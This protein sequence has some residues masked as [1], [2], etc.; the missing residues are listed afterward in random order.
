MPTNR[1]A[2][3]LRAGLGWLCGT[4]AVG[5]C[6]S[7]AQADLKLDTHLSSEGEYDT[8]IF[9][10][11]QAVA[12]Q[13]LGT[14]HLSDFI[15]DSQA[16]ADVAYGLGQQKLYASG[17]VDRI[18]YKLRTG[19][20]HNEFKWLGGMDWKLGD[21]FNGGAEYKD[22]RR[23]VPE[24]A[25]ATPSTELA[26]ESD[27]SAGGSFNANI[28]PEWLAGGRVDWSQQESPSPEVYFRMH[29]TTY[30]LDTKYQ[31]LGYISVGAQVQYVDGKAADSTLSGPFTQINTDLTLDYKSGS[32]SK[33]SLLLG[34]SS[35]RFEQGASQSYSSEHIDLQ[36][37]RSLSAKTSL[38][39]DA[40]RRTEVYAVLADFVEE[41]GADVSLD[42]QASPKI[43]VDLLGS[44]TLDSFKPDI[45]NDRVALAQV[46]LNY[47][48]LTWLS[49][50]PAV[51]YQNR[52]SDQDLYDFAD[53]IVSLEAK[54]KF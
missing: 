41:T 7:P 1:K 10:V 42:W 11:S 18:L 53:T 44:Y 46:A 24:E 20:D 23:M 12:E 39:V 17:D 31:G 54:L 52:R 47:Q 28:T 6:G 13:T 49:F 35:I 19:L 33:L 9:R 48:P 51:H 22:S 8:D 5:I 4:L 26:F 32:V 34:G 40:F 15:L 29:E 36:Y 45:R 50:K 27:R 14:S 43:F 37:K 2:S 3:A 21:A 16:G 30:T 38:S 25:R